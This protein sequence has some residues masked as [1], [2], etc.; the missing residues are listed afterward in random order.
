MSKSISK[1]LREDVK[2]LRENIDE[3]LEDVARAL[4]SAA[5][6]LSDE[7]EEAIAR[8]AVAVRKAADALSDKAK[9]AKAM[10]DKAVQEVKDHP[11]VSAGAALTA[12]A[13]LISGLLGGCAS[14][15]PL[16]AS[17]PSST[18]HEIIWQRDLIFT[19]ADAPQALAGDLV[20][21]AGI[22]PWPGLLMVHGGGW[23]RRS[24]EDMAS[25][26][27]RFAE[28]G[29][30]VFN[31][32]HRFAPAYHFPEQVRD[33][34]QAV[35]WMRTQAGELHLNPDWIAGY[36]Y[37]SGAHLVAMLATLSP[38]SELHQPGT[39]LQAM[40]LGGAP[41]D[42]RRFRGG[43]LIPQLLGTDFENGFATYALASPVTHL[44]AD[45]PPVFLYHGALDALVDA[46]YAREFAVA[47]LPPKPICM[48]PSAAW[49]PRARWRTW[50]WRVACRAWTFL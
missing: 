6:S 46:D 42:L 39:R 23:S 19:P 35:R 34:Q 7:S 9:P 16:P 10:A 2:D 49:P 25:S 27:E 43:Q 37:S 4:R 12:A 8:A 47:I 50:P 17:Q 33:L 45:D 32:S 40:V 1:D 22:G 21:P 31:I 26:A 11:I 36:G 29:F 38:G 5:E 20:R 18:T 3:T 14:H 28:A 48:V 30:A 13:L 15:Q 44:S 41:T 24:R